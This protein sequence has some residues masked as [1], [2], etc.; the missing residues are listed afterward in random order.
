CLQIGTED[1]AMLRIEETRFSV[2]VYLR[3]HR[4]HE[5]GGIRETARGWFLAASDRESR[6]EDYPVSR[7][8]PCRGFREAAFA[9]SVLQGC[10][11]DG[12]DVSEFSKI[13]E[14]EAG[15]R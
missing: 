9:G 2:L 5:P 4:G 14:G 8:R 15:M 13:G 11:G 7:G 1:K 6:W 12:A 3:W 10:E